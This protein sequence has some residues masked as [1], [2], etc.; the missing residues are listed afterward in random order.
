M[1]KNIQTSDKTPKMVVG[2]DIGTT[3][4]LMVMGYMG[5]DGEINVCS[6]GKGPSTGVEYGLVFNLQK[7]IDEI[8]IALKQ[9]AASIDEP[10]SEVYVGVAGRHIKSIACTSSVTRPNGLDNMVR[11]EEVEKMLQDMK[12]MK[13]KG[14]EVIT[15]IPQ[16]YDVDER[17][18]T[19]PAGTLC[20]KLT[21]H[22]QLVTGDVEDVKRIIFSVEGAELE[23]KKLILEPIA[24][25]EVCL[26]EEE[27]KNGVALIDIGGGT[28][29]LVIFHEGVPV[30]IKVIPVGG[31]VITSDINSLGI[32]SE[33]AEFLKINHGNC[34]PEATNA[35]NFITIPDGSGY[36]MPLK[37]SEQNLAQVIHARVSEDILKPV[38]RAIDESGY[39]NVVR[40]VVITGGGACL[41]NMNQLAEFILNR[42]TRIGYPLVKVSK[43]ID[44]ALKNT[45]CSTA[46]GLLRLGC[47]SEGSSALQEPT[48]D[49]KIRKDKGNNNKG[50]GPKVGERISDFIDSVTTWFGN[51]ISMPGEG[52]N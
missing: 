23:A 16:Y 47:L 43:T 20:Q 42:H 15:V 12:S 4:I 29:D 10:I 52:T 40:N 49:V 46:L 28:T 38:K 25:G 50:E 3:K 6:Y 18:T 9:L 1:A 17:S 44:S 35:N 27:K 34:L 24:S 37:I 41:Q 39:A 11:P 13:V 7:T 5:E 32:T 33:Q 2:L 14:S 48:E 26:T 22:Y 19:C 30:S 31:Q 45:S 36:G 8:G 21:G 51:M